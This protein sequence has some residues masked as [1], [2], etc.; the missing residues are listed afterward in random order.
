MGI[1]QGGKSKN[2]GQT[3]EQRELYSLS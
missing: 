1:K 3:G 2:R